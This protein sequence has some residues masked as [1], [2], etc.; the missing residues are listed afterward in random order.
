MTRGKKGE[1]SDS[2]EDDDLTPRKE[3]IVFLETYRETDS[4]EDEGG[5]GQHNGQHNGVGAGADGAQEGEAP[6]LPK[7]Y[8]AL[9]DF[10]GDEDDLTFRAG[11]IICVLQSGDPDTW[12]CVAVL[13]TRARRWAVFWLAY[14]HSSCSHALSTL[15]IGHWV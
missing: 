1:S 3:S 9:Y 10:E 14:A 11:D 12:W 7:L 13:S 6:N 4:E 15:H 8:R 5:N 2:P